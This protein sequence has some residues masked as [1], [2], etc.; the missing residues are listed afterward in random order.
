M[1]STIG[2]PILRI[3]SDLRLLLDRPEFSPPTF[4]I[5]ATSGE[6][7]HS[8]FSPEWQVRRNELGVVDRNPGVQERIRVL[9]DLVWSEAVSS[10]D[11]R[12]SVV[13]RVTKHKRREHTGALCAARGYRVSRRH[14]GRTRALL[15]ARRVALGEYPRRRLVPRAAWH[16]LMRLVRVLRSPLHRYRPPIPYDDQ[17]E[18]HVNGLM[19]QAENDASQETTEDP[20]T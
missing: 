3:S 15:V 17:L 19:A 12:P 11:V 5:E 1:Y 20:P 13:D 4:D 2:L 10:N 9:L 14:V 6:A 18:A 16:P 7:A 8:P